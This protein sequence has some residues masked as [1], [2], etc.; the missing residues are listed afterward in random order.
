MA[1]PKCT[2]AHTP[3]GG[4]PEGECLH[5]AVSASL[6]KA[7]RV[8]PLS[9]SEQR[10]PRYIQELCQTHLQNTAITCVSVHDRTAEQGARAARWHIGVCIKAAA[11]WRIVCW[12]C[13]IEGKNK[14]NSFFWAIRGKMSQFRNAFFWR[15]NCTKENTE[16]VFNSLGKWHVVF[17]N[18]C[19]CDGFMCVAQQ[20]CLSLSRIVIAFDSKLIAG[21]IFAY[22]LTQNFLL[23]CQCSRRLWPH[24]R[25]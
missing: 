14:V 5:P 19:Y 12:S 25:N 21:I 3:F 11:S 17:H 20:E 24:S 22:W 2:E 10:E 9:L 7:A 1:H 13:R 16:I 6:C 4:V 23:T 8:G 15:G 18:E